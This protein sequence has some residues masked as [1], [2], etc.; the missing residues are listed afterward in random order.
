MYLRSRLYAAHN[1][2]S[3]MVTT[4]VRFDK[5]SQYPLVEGMLDQ[6]RL[7]PYIHDCL[8][9]VYEGPY[10]YNYRIFFKK[11]CLLNINKA[12]KQI[13]DD[14]DAQFRGDIL[15]MRISTRNSS[16]YVNF[17]E[18]DVLLANFLVKEYGILSFGIFILINHKVLKLYCEK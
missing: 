5:T 11:H 14:G 4:P 6:S 13:G 2:R 3:Y 15:I 12:I 10:K 1:T 8:I 16:S 7:Q 9:T 18:R 17:R